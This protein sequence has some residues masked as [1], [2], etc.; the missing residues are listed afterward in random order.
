MF[1]ECSPCMLITDEPKAIN[2]EGCTWQ[3]T[4]YKASQGWLLL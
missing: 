3:P 2:Q 4:S 1:K